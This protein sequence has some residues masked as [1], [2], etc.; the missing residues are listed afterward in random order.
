MKALAAEDVELLITYAPKRSLAN[1]Y[2]IGISHVLH[3][4]L[5]PYGTIDDYYEVYGDQ[6][7]SISALE[8]LF[9]QFVSIR[10]GGRLLW[11]QG[12]PL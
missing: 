12:D 4:A 9:G 5:V 7:V 6:D 2:A 1:G 8:K 10:L 3:Y 11:S